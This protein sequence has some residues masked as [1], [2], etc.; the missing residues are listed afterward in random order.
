MMMTSLPLIQ[1]TEQ[2]VTNQPKSSIPSTYAEA[3]EPIIFAEYASTSWCPNCPTATSAIHEL[4]QTSNLPFQ[5]V[6]LISDLNPIA[7]NRSWR[8]YFN[9][10]IPTVYFD[11]G[12]Q[13]FVGRESNVPSTA[14]V[15]ENLI[16]DCISRDTRRDIAIETEVTWEGNAELDITITVTNNEPS[17]YIGVLRS[18]ITEINS[19][20]S[21]STG[22][23]FHNAVLDM[24]IRSVVIL[25]PQQTKSFTKQWDGKEDRSGL[26]FGDITQDN[27]LVQSAIYHW[28]PTI[29]TGYESPDITQRYIGFYVDNSDYA[30]P[31]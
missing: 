23:P 10:A 25:G 3:S 30:N 31:T 14:V 20:W 19:R 12:F 17:L 13:N 7:R 21:G 9:V 16:I 22:E 1:A 8:G 5:Y 15:Y 4:E 26:N 29:H 24:P 18:F 11:G 6:T 28:K 27:I 2:E